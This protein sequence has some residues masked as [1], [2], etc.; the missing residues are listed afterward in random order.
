MFDSVQTV[1]NE[2]LRDW[3][4]LGSAQGGLLVTDPY[5]K[6]G[7]LQ[8]LDVITKLGDFELD[9]KGYIKITDDLK[10]NFQYAIPHLAIDNKVRATIMRDGTSSVIQVPVHVQRELLIPVLAGEYPSYFIHGPILFTT[11]TQEF[12]KVIRGAAISLASLESPLIQRSVERPSE[13]GHEL[14]ILGPRLFTHST[15]E[16]YEGI[17]FGVVERINGTDVKSLAHAAELLL[18]ST[19]EFV[20]LELKG[21]TTEVLTFRR[22]EI[23]EATEQILEDEG[24]RS[25]YSDDL[26]SVFEG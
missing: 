15:S 3:L 7:P 1:E 19:D 6:D 17:G 16:G 2:S 24:I 25:M 14:V 8:R 5:E 12:L 22:E 21:C 23:A 4:Q 13:P 9:R 10:L 20:K 26:K 11:P 18:K